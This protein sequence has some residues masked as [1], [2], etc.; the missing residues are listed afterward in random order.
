MTVTVIKER[1]VEILQKMF[2]KDSPDISSKS[3]FMED[4]APAHGSKI[5]MEC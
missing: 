3:V 2:Y 5:T 1:Y 4:E